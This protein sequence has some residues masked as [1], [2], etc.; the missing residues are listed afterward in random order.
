[1]IDKEFRLAYHTWL[2]SAF[3]E[4]GMQFDD[5]FLCHRVYEFSDLWEVY[6]EYYSIGWHD[7]TNK[8]ALSLS[9]LLREYFN[10]PNTVAYLKSSLIRDYIYRVRP[11]VVTPREAL[12]YARIDGFTDLWN[13][14][15]M[16]VIVFHIN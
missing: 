13:T 16:S 12:S 6:L 14:L 7:S 1:M 4:N 9:H 5:P 3:D 8:G 10:M 11:K 2:V 15:R